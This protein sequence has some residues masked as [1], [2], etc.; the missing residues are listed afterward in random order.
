MEIIKTKT[1]SIEGLSLRGGKIY[2]NIMDNATFTTALITT[3]I[4]IL[5]QYVTKIHNN[6][7]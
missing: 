6:V 1:P 7:S 4:C 5:N 2:S 3:T